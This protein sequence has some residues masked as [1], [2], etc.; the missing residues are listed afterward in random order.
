MAVDPQDPRD[1]GRDLP[2]QVVDRGSQI[3]ERLMSGLANLRLGRFK[4]YRGFEHEA[5]ADY[6]HAR[7]IAQ[8]L[9][10]ATEEIRAIAGELLDLLRERDIQARTEIGDLGLRFFF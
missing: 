1:V 3:I 5:I 7:P 8:N 4:K 9:A 6:A 10:Q 2:R